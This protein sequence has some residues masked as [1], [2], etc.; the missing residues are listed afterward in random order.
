MKKTATREHKRKA[1]LHKNFAGMLQSA[2][3]GPVCAEPWLLINDS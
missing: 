2:G 1:S 3:A